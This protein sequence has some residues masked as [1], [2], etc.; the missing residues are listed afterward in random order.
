MLRAARAAGVKRVVLT[1]SFVAIGI[2]TPPVAERTTKRTGPTSTPRTSAPIPNRRR[3]PNARPGTSSPRRA[4]RNW[5]PSIPS[6]GPGPVLGP[7]RLDLGRFHPAT[8]EWRVPGAAANRLSASSTCAMSLDL[9]LRAMTDPRAK[10]ERFFATA[11]D[12]MSFREIALTLKSRLGEAARRVPTR[13]LPDWL[14]RLV[15]LADP[16][17]RQAVPELGKTK[18]ATCEKAKRLLGWS[19]RS[20]ED[21]A[22]RH[23]R[24]P[25]PA[26]ALER[27]GAA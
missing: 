13:E 12:F 25:H 18:N 1:S 6:P 14:L 15:A 10:G 9:H 2:R 19:P 22:G 4:A 11:G 7:G 5:R 3:W 23:R 8:D 26:R 16:S 20:R 17:V 24:K 21:A 27:A